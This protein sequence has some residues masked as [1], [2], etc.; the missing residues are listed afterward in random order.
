[1]L[2]ARTVSQSRT[3]AAGDELDIC[4]MRGEDTQQ[5]AAFVTGPTRRASK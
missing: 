5:S 3:R 2:L 1:L 4:V